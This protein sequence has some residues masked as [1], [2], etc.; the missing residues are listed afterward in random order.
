VRHR[1]CQRSDPIAISAFTLR[2]GLILVVIA[3]LLPIGTLSVVQAL[4][5]LDYSRSLIGNQLIASALATAGRERDPIIIAH[6]TL[7]TLSASDAVRSM[8]PGCRDGLKAGLLGNPALANFARSDASGQARCSVIPFK[9]PL[10]FASEGWWQRG[11]KQKGFSISA[12]LFG[13]ISKQK[14]LI[15]MLPV[16]GAD[17]RNDGAITTAISMAWL[18]KSLVSSSKSQAATIA[19]TDS[20][21]QI[22]LLSGDAKLPRLKTAPAVG[23]IAEAASEDGTIWMYSA[24]PLY[25]DALYIVYAE[26]RAVVMATALAQVKIDLILPILAILLASLALWVGTNTIV[27]KWLASLRQLTTQFASGNFRGDPT[28]FAKAPREIAQLSDEL[29]AMASTIE[30]RDQE[31]T[32]ALAAK[33]TL[34]LE[35]HHRVKNNLQIVSSLL[36][37]QAR[38]IDDPAARAALSQTRAR[39]GALA[40]IHRLLYEDSNG[41]DDGEV[42]IGRLLT[43]LCIQLRAL[44]RHQ[45]TINL[46]CDAVQCQLPVDNAVPLSLFAVEA[47]TNGFCHGFPEGRAGAIS[48]S[49]AVN[50]RE[51]VLLI[52]DDGI[53][54]ATIN[55]SA[56]MGHQLMEAFAHQ[57]GAKLTIVSDAKRGTSVR[58]AYPIGNHEKTARINTDGRG[59]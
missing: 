14:V 26:P 35:I 34:T 20:A 19:V 11:I 37:L 16:T 8:G 56:S 44:H 6:H 39:I 18:E 36:N 5:S 31:L 50:D 28:R 45:A 32:S 4:A 23:Q 22:I 12:P 59:L 29:H 1:H 57:L 27:I 13:P 17:G 25:D 41:D 21:G 49:F 3:T 2:S 9:G 58:L 40:Q 51:A 43:D 38:R 55:E 10:S 15:G 52:V 33:T 53:G 54:Y 47:I 7:V 24:A 42:D 48:L 46:T 30:T